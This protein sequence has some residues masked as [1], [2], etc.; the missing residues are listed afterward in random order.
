MLPLR[1]DFDIVHGNGYLRV[2][3]HIGLVT[4]ILRLHAH[5]VVVEAVR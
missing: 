5:A 2:A 4:G 1:D 3:R